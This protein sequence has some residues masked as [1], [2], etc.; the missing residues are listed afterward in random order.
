M[1]IGQLAVAVGVTVTTVRLYERRGLISLPSRSAS[2]YREYSTEAVAE[3]R[4]IRRLE[5]LGFTHSEIRSVVNR[6]GNVQALR[7]LVGEK[8]KAL[9]EEKCRLSDFL[10]AFEDL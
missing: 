8:L 1:R 2:G 3:I 10:S 7:Q 9:E 4:A 5:E 6:H